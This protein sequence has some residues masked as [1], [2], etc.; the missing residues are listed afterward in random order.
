MRTKINVLLAR[1]EHTAAQFTELLKNYL[2]TFEKKQG[3]FKGKR[4]EYQQEP[5]TD[6]QPSLRGF[7]AVQSTVGEYLQWFEDTCKEYIDN[8]FAVEATNATGPKAELIV[9]GISWGQLTTLELLR[10]NDFLNNGELHKMY[11]ALPVR[12][13]TVTWTLSKN[14]DMADRNIYETEN[15]EQHNRTTIKSSRILPDPNLP[16]LKDTKGY[17]PQLVPDDKTILLGIVRVQDFSGEISHE[18]RAKILRR[19][20]G[21]KAAVKEALAVANESATVQSGL[22]AEKIFGYLHNGK[23]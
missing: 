21:L 3:I 15:R 18:E 5:D 10:L 2:Q 19:L 8:R 4:Q 11:A 14:K 1:A 20:T 22:T 13:D 23:I 6:D 7:H 16:Q 17:I 12:P 9:E